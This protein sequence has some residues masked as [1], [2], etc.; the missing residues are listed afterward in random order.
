MKTQQDGAICQE[1][2]LGIHKCLNL[3]LPLSR[4]YRKKCLAFVNYLVHGTLTEM[5]EWNKM[6][7]I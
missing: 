7:L 4:T 6:L 5:P 2:A 1:E 3:E